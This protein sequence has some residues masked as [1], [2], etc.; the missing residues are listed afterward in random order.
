VLIILPPSESKRPPADGSPP[1]DL[2]ELSFPVLNPLRNEIL[3]ALIATSRRPDALRR[4]RVGP[5]IA[6]EVRRNVMLREAPTAA[7]V[8]VYRGAFYQALDPSTWSATAARTSASQ[9]VIVS[10]LFGALRPADEIPAYRLDLHSRLVGIDSLKATWRTILPEVLGEA[11]GRRGAV[12]DLRSPSY[13]AVGMAEGLTER[14]VTVR[15]VRDADGS[16]LIGDVIP[17]RT[18]GWLARHLLES[19]EDPEHPAALTEIVADRWPVELARPRRAT[20]T[21]TLTVAVPA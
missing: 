12:L 11:A 19:G 4:L 7:A 6:G 21:W 1:L 20:Q 15:V 13:Q 18:R 16:G 5:S 8:Q 9:L 2:G 14:T 10:A 17:K 3:G